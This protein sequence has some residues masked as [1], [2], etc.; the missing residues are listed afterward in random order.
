VAVH[1]VL[2]DLLRDSA[3]IR[4]G[5]RRLKVRGFN[6]A[7]FVSVSTLFLAAPKYSSPRASRMESMN[8]LLA[9]VALAGSAA[10]RLGT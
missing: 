4:I 9:I 7:P 3:L 1:L 6:K 5:W 2:E 10:A 8:S